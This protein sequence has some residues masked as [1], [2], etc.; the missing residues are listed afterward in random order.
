MGLSLSPQRVVKNGNRTLHAVESG[1]LFTSEK[2]QI[3]LLTRDAPLVSIGKP[4]ILDFDQRLP[5]C[6]EGVFFNLHNNLWGTNFPMW[7]ADDGMFEFTIRLRY[8]S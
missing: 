2:Y 6:D 5:L 1:L 7:Y 4:R 3:Q 8:N